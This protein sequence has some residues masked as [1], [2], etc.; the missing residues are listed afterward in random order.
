MVRGEGGGDTSYQWVNV[1]EARNSSS[2]PAISEKPGTMV[3]YS[4]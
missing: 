3:I 1:G 4:N 2:R